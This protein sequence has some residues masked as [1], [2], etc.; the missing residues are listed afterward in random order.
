[1]PRKTGT[2]HLKKLPILPKRVMTAGPEPVAS[3]RDAG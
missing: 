3:R 1:V 2:W